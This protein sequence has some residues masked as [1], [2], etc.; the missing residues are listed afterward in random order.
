MINILIIE[1]EALARKKM[2]RF[3]DACCEEYH[4]VGEVE[5][6]ESALTLL[7]QLTPIAQPPTNEE[8]NISA[9]Q[10]ITKQPSIDIIFSDIELR[11]GNAFSIFEQFPINCPIIFATA[12]NEYLMDAFETNGIEYLLK[13]YSLERFQKA[14]NKFIK[15]RTSNIERSAQN[16]SS[17]A[18]SLQ[19][20]SNYQAMI[21]RLGQLLNVDACPSEYKQK[22][23]IR[24]GKSTYFIQTN[25]VVYFYADSGLVFAIDEANKSHCTSIT[26]L[27]ELEQSLDPKHFFRIN[28]S[29]LINQKY[30]DKVE[31]F[32]KN[33][34][35]VFVNSGQKVLKTSQS[36]TAQFNHWIGL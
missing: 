33:T 27:S 21:S 10:S 2:L 14:W 16:D 30:I 26:S 11:D 28:R 7:S 35:N 4:I 18:L 13:P 8:M 25:T 36:R 5:S 31:R 6:V 29:E 24:S 12:Y 23:P 19:K 32:C 17:E 1:D 15:L 9:Q 22:L 3:I 20:E 34:L